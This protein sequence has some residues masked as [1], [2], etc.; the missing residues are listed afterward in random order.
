MEHHG[1]IPTRGADGRGAYI[2][3]PTRKMC[4]NYP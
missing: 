1:Q 3:T 2:I 4:Q